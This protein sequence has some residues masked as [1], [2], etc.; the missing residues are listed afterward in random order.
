M[1]MTNRDPI[2]ALTLSQMREVLSDQLDS[3]ARSSGSRRSASGRE[4]EFR[5]LSPDDQAERRVRCR[6]LSKDEQAAG[7]EHQRAWPTFGVERALGGTGI[8]G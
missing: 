7:A 2:A 4:C 5:S 1:L 3:S 8:A 6:L